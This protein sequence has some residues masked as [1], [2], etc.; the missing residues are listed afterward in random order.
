M[1]THPWRQ[2]TCPFCFNR[3]R[4]REAPL[5]PT[6]NVAPEA[7]TKVQGFFRLAE[8]PQLSKVTQP[9]NGWLSFFRQNNSWSKENDRI[10]PNCHLPLPLAT[11]TGQLNT[12]VIAVIGEKASG[13]SNYFAVLLRL[14]IEGNF[15]RDAGFGVVAQPTWDVHQNKKVLSSIL[16][17]ERYGSLFDDRTVVD[18][19]KKLKDNPALRAPLIYRLQFSHCT[20]GQR[21]RHPLTRF[22]ATDLVLF[23][24]AGEDMQNPEEMEQNYRYLATAAGVIFLID[25]T[26]LPNVL[27]QMPMDIQSLARE[28]PGRA[29]QVVDTF[30][31]LLDRHG[32]GILRTIRVPVAFAFT[33]LDLLRGIIEPGSRLLVPSRH[34]DGFDAED[35]Q[36]TSNE[37]RRHLDRWGGGAVAT[38]LKRFSRAG[39]FALSSL[40]RQPDENRHVRQLSPL[41]VV[42]PLL[43]VL[44]QLGYLPAM[45]T[46]AV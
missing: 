31:N 22:Q 25:P 8:A 4:L 1:L 11:A 9:M 21:I 18:E 10:C 16:F 28:Y 38:N 37:V 42:D 7:D 27:P 14:L 6:G 40:G 44:N 23:D 41:R 15:A 34:H 3:F 35:F 26:R 2:A 33:K 32:S 30:L 46:T 43:W 20:L 45:Q 36:R 17:R 29:G 19:T 24:T 5:R 13:K 39:F 12:K